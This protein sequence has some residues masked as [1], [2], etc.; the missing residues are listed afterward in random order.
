MEP[1]SAQRIQVEQPN[2][3]GIVTLEIERPDAPDGNAFELHGLDASGDEVASARLFI[4]TVADIPDHLPGNSTFGAEIDLVAAGTSQ[5]LL[6]RETRLI[7]IGPFS[8]A[9][10]DFLGLSAVTDELSHEAH[11]VVAPAPATGPS[12]ETTY[13][14]VTEACPTSYEYSSPTAGGCCITGE[15]YEGEPLEVE[16]TMFVP[17]SGA[18]AGDIVTRS[19]NTAGWPSTDGAPCTESNGTTACNSAD[20]NCYYGPL[21]FANPVVTTGTGTAH[22]TIYIGRNTNTCQGAFGGAGPNAY[23]NV[24]GEWARS[25]ANSVGCCSGGGVC[26]TAGAPACSTCG[27]GDPAQFQEYWEY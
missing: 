12:S 3:L 4:G 13:S 7:K 2:P 23:G 27:G 19:F 15:G 17:A 8:G 26:G 20:G 9:L 16:S 18:N 14:L 5:R 21:G 24:T 22:I 11:I 25:G 6:T 1:P 10:G